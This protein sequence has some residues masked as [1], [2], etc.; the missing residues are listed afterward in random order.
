MATAVLRK[1][2]IGDAP[3]FARLT[4]ELGYPV[5]TEDMRD[6][7]K[8][9]L[10]HPDH[11][12]SVV[13]E[14][15]ALVGWIAVEHR[16]TLESGERVEI[17]GLVVD[18]RRRGAGVGRMLVADAEQWAHRSG[19]DAIAVRSNI[20]REDSHPFYQRLGYVK[21]KTQHF[22]LKTLKDS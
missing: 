20:L 11:H 5:S 2:H 19:F 1:A 18:Q 14:G 10:S 22:Y 9:L 12:I 6:R 16:R 15:D 3:E 8:L 17:V 4:A 21:R 13:E 7:L